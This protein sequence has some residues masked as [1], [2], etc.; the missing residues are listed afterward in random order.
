M[1]ALDTQWLFARNDRRDDFAVTIA[2]LELLK[3]VRIRRRVDAAI[4]NTHLLNRLNVI[5][6]SHL[7]AADNGHAAYLDRVEPAAPFPAERSLQTLLAHLGYGALTGALYAALPR[8]PS[9]FVYGPAIWALSYL[10]WLPG[11]RI[12][13][14]AQHHPAKRNLLMLAVHLV[15]G[16]TLAWSLREL[17]ASMKDVFAAGHDRDHP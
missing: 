2:A 13:K 6:N 14:P 15:W 16:G 7:L 11:L 9:G 5:V 10:G 3:A 8:R 4:I 17:E 1:L 12:L